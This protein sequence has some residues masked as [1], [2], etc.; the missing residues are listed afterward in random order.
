VEVATRTYPNPA[1]DNVTF[2]FEKPTASAWR[3]L[4]Y[5]ANG[6][7]VNLETVNQPNGKV[8]H[9]LTLGKELANGMYFYHLLDENSVIRNSGKLVVQH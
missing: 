6:E 2:E 8:N 4:I 1:S 7:M 9:T 5:N 3:I